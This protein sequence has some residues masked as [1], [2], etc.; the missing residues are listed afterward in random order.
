MIT[1][2]LVQALKYVNFE[3]MIWKGS[4]YPSYESEDYACPM[5][6]LFCKTPVTAPAVNHKPN[7]SFHMLLLRKN[8]KAGKLCKW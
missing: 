1:R 3:S 8:A 4:I 5:T 6:F 2:L 7:V